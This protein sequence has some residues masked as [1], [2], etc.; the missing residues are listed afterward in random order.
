M[1]RWICKVCFIL[2]VGIGT[3]CF[4]GASYA[5]IT[6]DGTFSEGEWAGYFAD[7]DGV[8]NS[9]GYVDPGY[10]GQAFD[11]EYL[12]LKIDLVSDTMYFVLQTGFDVR[13]KTSNWA[14][15]DFGINVDGDPFYEY[16]IRFTDLDDNLG[17]GSNVTFVLYQVSTWKEVAYDAHAAA[18]PWIMETKKTG[19]TD[20]SSTAGAFGNTG[21]NDDVGTSYVLEGAFTFSNLALWSG[22]PVTSHWTMQCGNDTLDVTRSPVPEPTTIALLGIGLA[23]LAGAEVRRRRKKKAVD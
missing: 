7:D 2:V 8:I 4:S 18:N 9:A 19:S 14:S 5:I 22:G 11:V 23:G 3:F 16:A 17:N 1:K 12:G 13:T 15:G 21:I 10:G 6:V 20:Y